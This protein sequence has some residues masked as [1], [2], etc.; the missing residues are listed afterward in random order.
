MQKLQESDRLRLLSGD[1]AVRKCHIGQGA[2]CCRF[3]GAGTSGL[4]CLAVISAF[5]LAVDQKARNGQMVARGEAC[6]DPF[7]DHSETQPLQGGPAT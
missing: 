2:R 5:R 6:Q 4:E 1:E 3:L 7:D